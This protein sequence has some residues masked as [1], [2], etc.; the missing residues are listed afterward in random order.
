M[1]KLIVT[2]MDGTLLNKNE[3]LDKEFFKIFKKLKEKNIL[4]AV[5]SG[6][7]RK[8]LELKFSEIKD[9]LIMLFENGSCGSLKGET[10]YKSQLN[11]TLVHKFI[12]LGRKNSHNM[13]LCTE[14][15]A[16]IENVN[17]EFITELKKYF[18]DITFVNDLK[19]VN[20]PI[21]K[22][23]IFDPKGAK[24]NTFKIYNSLFGNEVK[25]S[26]ST[27]KWLHI[28]NKEVSKGFGVQALQNHFNISPEETMV[29]GDGLND[30]EM[31]KSAK[32]SYAMENAIDELKLIANF[33]A[34]SNENNGVLEV[35]KNKILIDDESFEEEPLELA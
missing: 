13:L 28:I 33:I 20:K 35:I 19:E 6:R 5:A 21:V 24:E 22:F 11:K 12:D 27:V 7:Q 16:Y 14:D 31:I 10:L 15:M 17:E 25:I 2:D 9:D 8:N 26:V 32:Y 23:T 3:E 30:L 29:F 18:E 34:P 4:F 1:I